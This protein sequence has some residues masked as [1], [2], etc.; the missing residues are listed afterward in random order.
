M[1]KDST[2]AWYQLYKVKRRLK[3]QAARAAAQAA[4]TQAANVITSTMGANLGDS[5]DATTD[6]VQQQTTGGPAP[7]YGQ[8]DMAA[9]QQMTPQQFQNYIRQS[10]GKSHDMPVFLMDRQFQRFTHMTGDNALPQVVDTATFNKMGRTTVQFDDV[11]GMGT[12]SVS[13]PELF[14]TVREAKVTSLGITLSPTDIM[15]QMMTNEYTIHGTG[16]LMGDGFYFSNSK[17]G[18]LSYANGIHGNI[19]KAGIF[20]CKLKD[21]AKV[22]STDKLYQMARKD[23]I[24]LSRTDYNGSGKTTSVN[25]GAYARYKGYD[26]VSDMGHNSFSHSG[27]NNYTVVVN[28]GALVMEDTISST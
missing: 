25:V 15:S 28:R 18:S 3:A 6:Q 2:S 10:D 8:H 16:V 24:T 14:R 21:G 23:G 1:V 20:R 4:A 7:A 13:S 22:V 27:S 17:N 26:A 11:G 5:D 12:Q 9:V 19:N